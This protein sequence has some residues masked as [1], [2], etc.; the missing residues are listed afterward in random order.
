MASAPNKYDTENGNNCS[1]LQVCQQQKKREWCSNR[2][3]DKDLKR[4]TGSKQKSVA[5]LGDN[6]QTQR[7]R[8]K[9]A[10]PR[11]QSQAKHYETYWSTE[12]VSQG[13]KQGILLQGEVRVNQKNYEEAYISL[14]DGGNDIL[15][16]GLKDRNRALNGDVV[17][18]Q[19][20]PHSEWKVINEIRTEAKP[21]TPNA[22]CISTG[23]S[24][25][26]M[27][28]KCETSEFVVSKNSSQICVTGSIPVNVKESSADCLNFHRKEDKL[29]Q[30]VGKVV[31]VIEQKHS[32]TV[33]GYLKPMGD[34]NPNFALFAPVDSR[35][36]RIIIPMAECPSDLLTREDDY[37]TT[38]FIAKLSEWNDTSKMATGHLNVSS[39]T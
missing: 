33:S 25:D 31:A 21:S 7:T 36:S 27:M 16:L 4:G 38:L 20:K 15:I 34:R 5:G 39:M 22:C 19:L 3:D 13:L 18:L 35:V 8:Q 12:H 11:N 17:A 32:R 10:K 23:K 14:P 30:K 2:N 9:S 28:V 37:T 24:T 6:Y 26:T 1:S 29:L